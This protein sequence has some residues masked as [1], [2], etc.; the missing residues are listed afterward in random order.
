MLNDLK[1][2]LKR[3]GIEDFAAT[4]DVLCAYVLG[5]DYSEVRYLRLTDALILSES[6]NEELRTLVERR[7]KGEPLEYLTGTRNFYGFDFRCRKNVLIPRIETEILVDVAL[8]FVED[9]NR[10]L[11]LCTGT[12][13]V[14]ISIANMRTVN[15]VLADK[16]EYAVECA[17]ENIRNMGIGDRVRAVLHDVFNDKPE[18]FFDIVTAN[19]PYI[20]YD[21][22][23]SLGNDVLNEPELALYGG[24]DGL[25]FY[26]VI[27]KR[28]RSFMNNGGFIFFE[29]GYRQSSDVANILE[30]NGYSD[31]AIRKDYNNIERV[32][33]ARNKQ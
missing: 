3:S 24:Y 22:M 28:Y 8:E 23:S 15:V 7:C 17:V 12:G 2:K 21:E 25:D 11:D 33:F 10:I 18:G 6:Q 27:A 16:S 13:C 31:I 20:S 14:G 29:T 4:L 32:V 26:R 30:N 9:G 19:P 5:K 1:E